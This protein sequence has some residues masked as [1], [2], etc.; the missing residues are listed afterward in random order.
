MAVQQCSEMV[1]END[2]ELFF[3]PNGFRRLSTAVKGLKAHPMSISS[4]AWNKYILRAFPSD[5]KSSNERL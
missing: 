3:F 1:P 2:Q 4:H 5:F